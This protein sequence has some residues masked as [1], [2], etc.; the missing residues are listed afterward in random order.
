VRLWTILLFLGLVAPPLFAA[1][2]DSSQLDGLWGSAI[3]TLSKDNYS[4]AVELMNQ[5]EQLADQSGIRSPELHYNLGVAY[6]NLKQPGLAVLHLLESARLSDS[7]LR[8][9]KTLDSVSEIQRQQGV[10][11]NLADAAF[12]R[13]YFLIN[14]D[15]I[16]LFIALAFWTLVKALILAWWKGHYTVPSQVLTA[17][18]ILFAV[19]A[20]TGWLNDRLYCR[21]GVLADLTG[22]VSVYN[23]PQLKKEQ[24]LVDLPSGTVINLSDPV[25]NSVPITAPFAGWVSL[26]SVQAL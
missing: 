17:L 11:D 26:E 3:H 13:F 10:K 5:W 15:V 21:F 24:L 2:A 25:R 23:G 20:G 14:H 18:A 22:R 8:I 4:G 19:V 16:W 12:L 9:W 6:L 7:P 1:P